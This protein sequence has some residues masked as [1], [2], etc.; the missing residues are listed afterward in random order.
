MILSGALNV[1]YA[2]LWH[3][4]AILTGKERE[5]EHE[6]TTILLVLQKYTFYFLDDFRIL[7]AIV[8]VQAASV[9]KYPTDLPNPKYFQC[10]FL[11]LLFSA[12]IY[13]WNEFKFRYEQI[14]WSNKYI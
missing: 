4:F 11:K 1:I 12:S 9:P 13:R 5:L 10:I 6:T 7:A 2:F 3:F 8:P 14:H